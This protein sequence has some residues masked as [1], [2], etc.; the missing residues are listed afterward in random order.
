MRDQLS[1]DTWIVIGGLDR[2]IR[3][4]RASV[5]TRQAMVQGSL[6]RVMTGLLAFAGLGAESMVRDPGWHFMDAGRR[7]ERA[8]Q[9]A[10][11]LRATVTTERD[12]ATDSLLLE[13]VLTTAESIITY[14]RRYRSQAQLETVLELLVLDRGNP[15]SLAHQLHALEADLAALPSGERQ[16]RLDPA[17]RLALEAHTALRVIDPA[18]LAKADST[19][20]RG[21]LDAYLARTIEL[22]CKTA[23]AID[24]THFTHLPPQHALMG[25]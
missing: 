19:G 8:I 12:N 7:V 21:D 1:G 24:S 16:G 15:R 13:S 17:Q 18:H 14:R 3:H 22:L 6:G 9:L 25:G 11:L 5:G 23:D 10:S 2:E 4:L 20:W